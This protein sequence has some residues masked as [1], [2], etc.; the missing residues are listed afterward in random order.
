MSVENEDESKENGV[1]RNLG[2]QPMDALMTLHAVNNHEV[3]AASKEPMT[4]KAVV[5]ARKGR[6]LTPHMQRRMVTAL[7]SVLKQRG[8]LETDLALTDV[9]N[10]KA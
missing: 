7:T 2:V 1:E 4:H 5:R 8:V 9:F 6:K 10:Y 3:V